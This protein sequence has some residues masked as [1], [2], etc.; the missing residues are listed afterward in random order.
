MKR[1]KRGLGFCGGEWVAE[2]ALSGKIVLRV[3][4]VTGASGIEAKLFGDLSKGLIPG[5][6]PLAGRST[7]QGVGA[8]QA[9]EG[10]GGKAEDAQALQVGVVIIRRGSERDHAAD[11]STQQGDLF[12]ETGEL[13]GIERSPVGLRQPG[14][15]K[16]MLLSVGIPRLTATTTRTGGLSSHNLF[17][18]NICSSVQ[19]KNAGWKMGKLKVEW[20]NLE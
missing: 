1:F 13:G 16:T 17:I 10:G 3:R 19:R 11:K 18:P 8:D 6:F 2:V 9:R 20:Y 5:L 15:I 4:R 7:Q 12:G 14:S